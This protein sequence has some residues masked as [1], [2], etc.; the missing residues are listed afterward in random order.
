MSHP[1]YIF[2]G[3]HAVEYLDDGRYRLCGQKV[4]FSSVEAAAMYISR[5]VSGDPN[6]STTHSLY[7]EDP[8]YRDYSEP[9]IESSVMG[10][11][12]YD[13]IIHF[14]QIQAETTC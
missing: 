4:T 9:L 11:N 7:T 10:D 2:N 5:L 3:E 13:E 8:R 14:L 12:L 1:I 6:R